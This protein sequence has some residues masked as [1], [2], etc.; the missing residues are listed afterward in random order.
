MIDIVDIKYAAKQGE[1]EF[2]IKD[3]N[4]LCKDIKSGEVV[5][6]SD[7]KLEQKKSWDDFVQ[8]ENESE[9]DFMDR[10]GISTKGIYGY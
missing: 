7:N 6:V 5:M 9:K 1:I 2:Y 4:I 10:N 8:R 3:N